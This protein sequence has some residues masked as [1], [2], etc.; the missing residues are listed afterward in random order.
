MTSLILRH[1]TATA[2]Q[3]SRL[4]AAAFVVLVGLTMS[5]ILLAEIPASV[6]FPNHL[7]RM[8]V[9]S[10]DGTAAAHPLYQT[11]WALYPNLAMDLGVPLLGRWI[12]IEAAAKLFYVVSQLLVISG[13]LALEL[14]VKRRFQIAGLF[15]PISLQHP[16]RLGL[17]EL[18]VRAR[19]CALGDRRLAL[20]TG[21]AARCAICDPCGDHGASLREPSIRP[22]P[23]R[24]RHRRS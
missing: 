9:L 3:E 24:L 12:G 23:V 2:G 1:S 20:A 15:A 5:P 18:P 19:T 11:T 8:S 14:A 6:D 10:R 17:R 13:A 7:A 21:S 16:L 22:R 4:A